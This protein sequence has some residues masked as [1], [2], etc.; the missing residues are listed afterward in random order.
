MICRLHGC[1]SF[2]NT[3]AGPFL[4]D[5]QGA[6]IPAQL[7]AANLCR[8]RKLQYFW[9]AFPAVDGLTTYMFAYADPK[10]GAL[11]LKAFRGCANVVFGMSSVNLSVNFLCLFYVHMTPACSACFAWAGRASLEDM[12]EDYLR[13]LPQYRGCQDLGPMQIQRAVFGYVPNWHDQPLSPLTSRLLQVGDAAG[14]RSA[15]SFA[16]AAGFADMPL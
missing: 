9:E 4:I 8:E 3:C 15:L 11:Q 2:Y 5:C 7:H 1:I 10:P 13:L 12:Y 6:D 14:N 16:G